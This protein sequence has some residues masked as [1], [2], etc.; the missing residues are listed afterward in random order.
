MLEESFDM[1]DL[2]LEVRMGKA[3]AME[4]FGNKQYGP[5]CVLQNT[6]LLEGRG[7]GR[8]EDLVPVAVGDGSDRHRVT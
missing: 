7:K 8:G 3:K 5:R 4:G 2:L 6:G 1:T